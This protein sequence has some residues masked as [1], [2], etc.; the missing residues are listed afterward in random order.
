MLGT[1]Y[2]YAQLAKN[3]VNGERPAGA[4]AWRGFVAGAI[5]GLIGTAVKS[6]AEQYFPPR[7]PQA[8]APPVKLGDEVKEATTGE[9]LTE[10]EKPV[11]EQSTHWLFGTLVGGAY[12]AAVEYV[13]QL[14]EGMGVPF[15][16]AVFGLMHE[17]VLPA[18]GVEEPHAEKDPTEERNEMITHLAYGFVTE[19]VRA[20]VRKAEASAA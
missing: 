3:L 4:S 18:M 10:A 15:G 1:T 20:Q 5:G 16:T 7:P 17:G 12:G 2:N 13:P 14:Q 8:D 19:V 11:V 9:H 6:L